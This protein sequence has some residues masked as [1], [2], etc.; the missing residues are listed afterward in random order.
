[1]TEA[2]WQ[3]LIEILNRVPLTLSEK[4]W[5]RALI[6]RE[7]EKFIPAP[8]EENKPVRMEIP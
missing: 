1:M 2:E 8:P 5:L 4:M 7:M 3:A 6:A